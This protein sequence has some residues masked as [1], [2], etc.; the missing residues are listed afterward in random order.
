M[1]RMGNKIKRNKE[2]TLLY[3]AAILYLT[4]K[5]L[6]LSSQPKITQKYNKLMCTGNLVGYLCCSLSAAFKAT[7]P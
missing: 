4:C 6:C 7:L 1:H 3:L 5:E 2:D